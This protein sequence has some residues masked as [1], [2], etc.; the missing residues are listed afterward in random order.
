MSESANLSFF[1]KVFFSG[2]LSFRF[3]PSLLTVHDCLYKNIPNWLSLSMFFTLFCSIIIDPLYIVLHGCA[4]PPHKSR[5]DFCLT[6]MSEICEVPSDTFRTAFYCNLHI[7]VNYSSFSFLFLFSPVCKKIFR[8]KMFFAARKIVCPRN[9][10]KRPIRERFCPRKFLLLKYC[11][12][13]TSYA[14]NRY[15]RHQE[16]YATMRSN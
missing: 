9:F 5:R 10:S 16:P 13:Y 11:F 4:L 8:E 6:C 7:K 3:L 2:F 14:T 1:L 15:Y 12:S